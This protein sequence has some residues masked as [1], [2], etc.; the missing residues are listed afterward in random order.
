MPCDGRV[1]E[2]PGAT[3]VCVNA[4][5]E[6][7]QG[8]QCSI[9]GPSPSSC[10]SSQG[11][12]EHLTPGS[13]FAKGGAGDSSLQ[14]WVSG[15]ETP[16]EGPLSDDLVPRGVP[17]CTYMHTSIYKLYVHKHTVHTWIHKCVC[18]RVLAHLQNIHLPVHG[19]VYC[20][21]MLT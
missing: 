8:E 5:Q 12:G 7:P 20:V 4:Q 18:T 6:Q 13:A 10:S 21:Y 17:A 2:C 11:R 9:W 15:L 19:F 16:P 3:C 1:W 14:P